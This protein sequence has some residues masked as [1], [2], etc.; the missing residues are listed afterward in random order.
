MFTLQIR[1]A[2]MPTLWKNSPP[3]TATAM[4]MLVALVVA[5]IGLVFDARTIAGAPA[6]L[7]PA[8]FAVSFLIYCSS[9]MWILRLLPEWP[10]VRRMVGWTTAV[11]LLI[12]SILINTQVVRGTASHFNIG[13]RF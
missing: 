6:W 1:S 9:L 10:R 5:A 12:E 7:K 4:V 13:T 3:L 8:K 2:V 11:T